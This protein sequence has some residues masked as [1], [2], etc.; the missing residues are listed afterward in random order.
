M[1]LLVYTVK[2]CKKP[3]EI[4]IKLCICVPLLFRGRKY[5]EKY[6]YGNSDIEIIGLLGIFYIICYNRDQKESMKVGIL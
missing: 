4:I 1:P 3:I 5:K 2:K 6:F